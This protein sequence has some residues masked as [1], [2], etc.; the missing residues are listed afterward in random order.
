MKSILYNKQQDTDEMEVIMLEILTYTA[1]I[2]MFDFEEAIDY[3]KVHLK[4]MLT[5]RQ[6]KLNKLI[7]AENHY[8]CSYLFKYRSVLLDK[9]QNHLTNVP[10]VLFILYYVYCINW[11]HFY[12]RTFIY[13]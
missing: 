8:P 2:E 11:Q 10:V 3:D 1:Y 6:D 13:Y 7:L 9:N 12:S 4:H 5:E